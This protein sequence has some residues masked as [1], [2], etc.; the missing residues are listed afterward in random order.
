MSEQDLYGYCFE[1]L[2][3]GMSASFGKTITEADVV[4]FAG[5]SGDINPAH[6]N[7]EFARSTRFK[8]RV[9]HGAL[10]ASLIS[11]VLGTKLPGPGCLYVSQ[12]SNFR[13]P[14]K[15]GET[16]TAQAIVSK[17]DAKRN[18]VSFDTSCYVGETL[19]VDGSA[20]LWV[21]SRKGN[22]E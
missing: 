9:A 12:T 17:L 2:S 1:D 11:A 5:I 16:V 10:S 20:L 4:L 13:A 21:P 18:F 7:E 14:V 15:P 3:V 6:I 8:T 19:V 22:Q